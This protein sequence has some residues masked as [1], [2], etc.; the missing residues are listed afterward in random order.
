M[1]VWTSHLRDV[2]TR[3]QGYAPLIE[4]FTVCRFCQIK[5]AIEGCPIRMLQVCCGNLGLDQGLIHH[6]RLL[7]FI[8]VGAGLFFR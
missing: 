2:H 7:S 4:C 8:S 1:Q 5:S 3:L 6:M